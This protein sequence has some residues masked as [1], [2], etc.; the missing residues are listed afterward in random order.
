M[1]NA[2]KKL[3]DEIKL[4]ESILAAKVALPQDF[5]EFKTLVGCLKGG[6]KFGLARKLLAVGRSQFVMLT[7]D[8]LVQ[9][10]LKGRRANGK[11]PDA[12]WMIQQQAICTYKDEELQPAKRFAK[13]LCLLEEVGL[14]N[15]S[16]T[17]SETL[18]LGGA[19]YRRMWEQGGQLDDLYKALSF[20]QAAWDGDKD[21]AERCYGGV[22]AAFIYDQ[23]AFR[24]RGLAATEMTSGAE[25]GRKSVNQAR[26]EEYRKR[27]SELRKAILDQL[28]EWEKLPV[29]IDYWFAVTRADAYLG[30]AMVDPDKFSQA[31]E[32]YGKAAEFL[33]SEDKDEKEWRLQTTFKQALYLARLHGYIPGE[34]EKWKPVGLVLT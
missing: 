15:K 29:A 13:A 7:Q 5:K 19:V 9:I 12:V 27:A 2:N 22:N 10:S 1:N 4:A 28:D 26:A 32:W 18:S 21:D 25:E 3:Q 24:L 11:T 17:N 16:T 20:Y 34:K 23:M 14:R 31:Q 8:D 6:Q 30:L 33:A